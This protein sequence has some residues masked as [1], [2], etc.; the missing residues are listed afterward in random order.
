M[1]VSSPA[2]GPSSP[3]ESAAEMGRPGFGSQTEAEDSGALDL[4]LMRAAIEDGIL[5]VFGPDGDPVPPQPFGAAAAEQPHAE[6]RLTDGPR[7]RAD[8][9]AA[10][11]TAQLGGRLGSGQGNDEAWIKA[12][13]GIGPR[14]EEARAEDLLSEGRSVEVIAFGKEL[15]MTSSVGGTFLIAEARSTTP[16]SIR[17]RGADGAPVSVADLVHRL[18]GRTALDNADGKR[19]QVNEVTL[20]DCR[21]WIEDG[22]LVIDLPEVGAVRFVR[23]DPGADGQPAVSV[24]MPDG[25]TAT[26]EELLGALSRSPTSPSAAA[27]RSKEAE[28]TI[29]DRSVGG[30]P[31]PALESSDPPGMSAQQMP[32]PVDLPGSFAAGLQDV[33]LV[34]I[35]GLPHGASL[36]A[37]VASGDGSWQL[38][39]Q[40]LTGLSLTPPPGWTLDFALEVVT[41]TVQN[42]DGE[43]ASASR[44]VLVPFQATSGRPPRAPI[45]I[46]VDPQLLS[47]QDV[48]L[49]AIVVR[50]MPP[51]AT[52]SA[53]AHDPEIG[54]WV[55]LPRQMSGLTLT[56]G[57][58]QIEDFTLTLLGISLSDGRARSRLLA[59]IPVAPG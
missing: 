47:A 9:I 43:L 11:L 51:E 30:D 44:T 40:D 54:G 12:M 23:A 37:G 58:G 16:P 10:V 20:P 52:L 26:I 2:Q 39:P 46:V 57:I 15:M 14:P 1:A 22:A 56:P 7:I 24:F 34:V 4:S 45:P 50:D 21:T 17:L 31:D 3:G 48:S 5:M 38:S 19:P 42:R 8:R 53:G 49:D 28:P 41:I 25:D 6:V 36:S 55:L 27:L 59:Q 13:L 32:L 29:T 35:R 18:L 33:A